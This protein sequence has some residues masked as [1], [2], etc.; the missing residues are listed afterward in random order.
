VL[1]LGRHLPSPAM[2]MSRPLLARSW[3]PSSF[4]PF[5][6]FSFPGS[7]SNTR[8]LV[9]K[10][11]KKKENRPC[12]PESVQHLL[13]K[14]TNSCSATLHDHLTTQSS[15]ASTDNICQS[16]FYKHYNHSLKSLNDI[17][18]RVRLRILLYSVPL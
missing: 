2:P 15:N 7:L 12:T 3:P 5:P 10:I 1:Y 14:R 13:S 11:Q 9:T 16:T 8:I 6:S 17:L 4:P 18:D